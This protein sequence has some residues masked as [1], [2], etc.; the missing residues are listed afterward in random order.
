MRPSSRKASS[1][2]V[3]TTVFLTL[4]CKVA[5]GQCTIK[6]GK[7][8][9][10]NTTIDELDKKL[11]E[12]F[13]LAGLSV[14]TKDIAEIVPDIMDKIP[15]VSVASLPT[16]L[17]S[18]RLLA[19]REDQQNALKNEMRE[20][21]G[22]KKLGEI[23][24]I[25]KSIIRSKNA[26]TIQIVSQTRNETRA[27]AAQWGHYCKPDR[28]HALIHSTLGNKSAREEEISFDLPPWKASKVVSAVLSIDAVLNDIKPGSGSEYYQDKFCLLV[29][30]NGSDP[31]R[32]TITNLQHGSPF[33]PLN[34]NNGMGF[35]NWGTEYFQIGGD[36]LKY[37]NSEKPN[38]IRMQLGCHDGWLVLKSSKLTVIAEANETSSEK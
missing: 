26:K 31:E 16:K 25:C 37:F 9:L 23:E 32:H 38:R 35:Q 19:T 5:Y 20:I 10:I 3:F 28:C 17:L 13:N 30:V 33:D 24:N 11:S 27:S 12:A 15:F 14:S 18:K 2:F 6:N 36:L 8:Y 21:L 4:F 1:A 29:Q 34:T 22:R 7:E